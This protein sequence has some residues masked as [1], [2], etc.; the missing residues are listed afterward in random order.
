[1]HGW[2]LDEKGVAMSKSLGN[3]IEPG[4]II[5]KY[6]IDTLRFYLL[7]TSAPWEDLPF[8]YET[9]KN[10]NK[11]FNILWNVYVFATTYMALDNFE[12]LDLDKVQNYLRIEDR[13]I[14]SRMESVKVNVAE[15]IENYNLHKATRDLQEFIL[16]DLSRW[17]VRLI[18]DRA[19][20]EETPLDK[21]AV[22][23]ALYDCLVNVS[24]LLVPFTPFI[25][26]EIYQNLSGNMP[27][28]CME[29][30]PKVNPHLIDK[31][32]EFQMEIVREITESVSNARQKAGIKLRWP[33]KRVLIETDNDDVRDEVSTL[34]HILLDQTNAKNIE[35]G[36]LTGGT[37]SEFSR[38]KIYVDTEITEELKA[39]AFAREIIRR[40]QEMRK[41]ANL[42][43]EDY[44][45]TGIT[46]N[47]K[48][49]NYLMSWL[50]FIKKETRS[51]SFEFKTALEGDLVKDWDIEGEKINLSIRKIG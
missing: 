38:G 7:S 30:W 37:A 4:E 26:E 49:S 5:K 12:N 44:I 51:K 16:E 8:S 31:K 1:M 48:F 40:V 11:M 41:Q 42:D 22:Y 35:F 6:G 24:L 46:A 21:K 23:K 47:E 34:S 10:V 13:W 18:K 20:L 19:W 17:Y 14:L 28:V 36:A 32:L 27:T 29:D 25:S 45:A 50:E 39:E 2:A 9:I 33:V 3:V 43:V 15:N